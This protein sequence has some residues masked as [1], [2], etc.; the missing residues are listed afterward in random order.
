MQLRDSPAAA[1]LAA[2]QRVSVSGE[3]GYAEIQKELK[4]KGV[5]TNIMSLRVYVQRLRDRKLITTVYCNY[6]GY[7]ATKQ[8]N[9]YAYFYL[10]LKGQRLLEKWKDILQT[11]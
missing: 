7:Q 8:S 9:K 2:I 10:T 6:R 1:V 5:K 3:V 4:N 11:V